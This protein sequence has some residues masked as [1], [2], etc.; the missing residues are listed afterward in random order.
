MGIAV[1]IDMTAA[2]E[3]GGVQNLAEGFKILNPYIKIPACRV[4]NFEPCCIKIPAYTL[5]YPF[6]NATKSLPAACF[7]FFAFR[8]KAAG[9]VPLYRLNSLLRWD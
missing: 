5:C 3:R 6:I 4:Q 9:V 8:A 7:P 1:V 2:I